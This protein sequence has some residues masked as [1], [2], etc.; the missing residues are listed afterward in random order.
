MAAHPAPRREERSTKDV[1]PPVIF[2][3][4]GV[5]GVIAFN[6]LVSGLQSIEVILLFVL[7]AF[8]AVG[9]SQGIIR[10]LM[11]A[12]I[13]YAASGIAATFYPFAAPYIGAPFGDE[14]DRNILALSFGVLTVV[15][16]VTLEVLGRASFRD[17]RMPALGILDNLGSLIVY[18]AVGVLVISLAFNAIGYGRVGRRAHNDSL[19][20]PEFNRVLYLHYTAQ[21]FWFPRRPPPIYVYDLDLPRG[22]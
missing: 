10:G 8:G 17:T 12:A 7:I 4:L 3:L 5:A 19:L 9:Y 2:S 21:S 22:P 18:L 14:V 15:I 6:Y 16:W 20:R 13:L 11:T 1:V